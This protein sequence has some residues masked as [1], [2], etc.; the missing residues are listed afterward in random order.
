MAVAFTFDPDRISEG[1]ADT[2]SDTSA[3]GS[4]KPVRRARSEQVQEIATKLNNA[5]RIEENVLANRVIARKEQPAQFI[6]PSEGLEKKVAQIWR[7]VL[8]VDQVGV[9]DNFFEIGGT[10]LKAV[11]VISKLRND[12]NQ[13]VSLITMF[14]RPNI[15][16]LVSFIEQESHPPEEAS[17]S[18]SRQRGEL[19]RSNRTKRVRRQRK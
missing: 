13:E 12:L 19:R 11:Q 18:A 10:S 14:D 8:G 2:Q 16:A 5:A 6:A 1:T 15:R 3:S 9:D 17:A 4:K 7:D